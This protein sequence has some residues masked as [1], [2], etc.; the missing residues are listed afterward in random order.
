M[1]PFADDAE[2]QI[3]QDLM[4]IENGMLCKGPIRQ[5]L[6]EYKVALSRG[7]DFMKKY[8]QRIH[9]ASTPSASKLCYV[10][11]DDHVRCEIELRCLCL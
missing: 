1:A 2:N 7:Y 11:G 5:R 3:D 8:E 9:N 6:K 4:Q 10:P